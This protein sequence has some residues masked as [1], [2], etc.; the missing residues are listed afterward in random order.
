VILALALGTLLLAGE[1]AGARAPAAAAPVCQSYARSS[2]AAPEVVRLWLEHSRD[3]HVVV[4]EPQ[5]AG[6]AEPLYSGESAVTKG[7]RV[8]S[9]AAHF[10]TRTGSG[11]ASRLH[12]YDRS[13]AVSMA[14]VGDG[15]CPP[16]HEPA[17]AQRYTMTYDLTPATF[18]SLM[19]FWGAAA[20]SA[21]LFDRDLACC[22]AEAAAAAD[23]GSLAANAVRLRLHAAIVAGRMQAAAVT[24]IVRVGGLGLHRRYALLV[25]DPDSQPAGTSVYVIYVSRFLRGAWHISGL[26]DVAP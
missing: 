10:L 17:T 21:S 23:A 24:R 2:L 16:P 14:V 6:G 8:C 1:S 13:E 15:A 5:A 19:A 7:A 11:S 4:C 12:R 9:Y 25:V 22:G 20:T 26:S 3:D 18:E